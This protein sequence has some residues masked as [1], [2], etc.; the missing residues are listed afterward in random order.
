MQNTGNLPE[1]KNIL[2][3]QIMTEKEDFLIVYKPPKMHSAPIKKHTD[4]TLFD[5]CCIQ[6]PEIKNLPGRKNGEGGLLHRL[7]YETHGLLIVARTKEGMENL[8]L[9]QK[10]GRIIKE[11]NALV[12]KCKNNL[13]GYPEVSKE[14][15]KIIKSAFRPYGAGRRSVR[16]VLHG[17]KQYITEIINM[18]KEKMEI[19]SARLK[20]LNGFRHQIRCH[21]S[22][23]GLP[24]INDDLY[25]GFSSVN[26]ILAL[27]AVSLT[28]NDIKNNKK[29]L[30]SIPDLE[31]TF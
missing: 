1:I 15:G 10:E 20:I 13:P 7:D 24:I 30:F 18:K 14:N 28:F 16:P 21:L 11:Y 4:N 2:L 27:R 5:W 3:P 26:G 25:G 31:N 29:I 17:E 12:K 6:Y 19:I 9:Q 8:I 23:I 22:W